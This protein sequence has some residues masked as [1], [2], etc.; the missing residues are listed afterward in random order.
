MNER[1]FTAK[2]GEELIVRHRKSA[3]LFYRET[4]LDIEGYVGR[5][6]TDKTPNVN[7]TEIERKY[8]FSEDV[9]TEFV[10]Y[11]EKI[12][13]ESWTSFAA[14]EADSAGA[15]YDEYYDKEFDNNG[16]LSIGRLVLRVE[17][18]F[19]PKTSNPIIRLYKFNK[20]KFESFIFDLREL[21]ECQH[22][23]P[24]SKETAR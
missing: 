21:V 11:M 1:I 14:K 8:T 10:A 22:D 12:A 17:G 13:Q 4:D 3:V 20:R 6:W 15:D 5:L 18:P 2:N 7:P 9:F 16:S 23:K 19:Q 24:C